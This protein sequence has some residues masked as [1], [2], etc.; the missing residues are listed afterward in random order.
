MAY[1]SALDVRSALRGKVPGH[2]LGPVCGHMLARV[3]L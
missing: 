1:G 3:G 2:M